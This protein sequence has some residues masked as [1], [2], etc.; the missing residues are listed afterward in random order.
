MGL[1]NLVGALESMA[2]G[3]GNVEQAFSQVAAN[4]GQGGLAS[5][6]SHAFQSDQTPPFGQMV[7]SMFGNSS[8]DQKAG[9][10]NQ[11]A[12][13]IGPQLMAS[14][15]L[16]SLGSLLGS[17]AQITPQQAAQV[18]PEDVQAVAEHAQKHN[19]SVVEEA[20]NF[21]AQHPTLV[22]GLGAAAMAMMMSHMSKSSNA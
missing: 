8:P 13:S 5:A 21:Y 6:L 10:L 14:G 19:P 16:G 20:S 2:G 17:G 18:S 3:S 22:Q 7:S 12:Q 11:L 9:L 4:A 1:G 15:A